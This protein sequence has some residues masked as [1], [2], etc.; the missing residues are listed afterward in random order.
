MATPTTKKTTRIYQT[1][2]MP[3]ALL[4]RLKILAVHEHTTLEEQ[5]FAAIEKGLPELE[6]ASRERRQKATR[7]EAAS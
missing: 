4:D 7:K 6:A 5:L 1:R 2:N 3:L